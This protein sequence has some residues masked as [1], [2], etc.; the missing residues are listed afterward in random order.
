MFPV[1]YEYNLH[2][3]SEAI[4]VTE[5]GGSQECYCEV[6]YHAHKAKLSSNWQ[7]RSVFPVR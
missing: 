5:Y 2:V 7:W 3:E 6:E 1:R 4:P